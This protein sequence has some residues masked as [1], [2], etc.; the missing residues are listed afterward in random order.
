MPDSVTEAVEKAVDA[1]K[2]VPEDLTLEKGIGYFFLGIIIV[3]LLILLIMNLGR[4]G[5]YQYM[6][7]E[8]HKYDDL[9]GVTRKTNKEMDEFLKANYGYTGSFINPMALYTDIKAID[10]YR[11]IIISSSSTTQKT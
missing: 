5:Y 9:R 7:M 4:F 3:F 10:E 8:Q 11:K 6:I 2:D 1:V